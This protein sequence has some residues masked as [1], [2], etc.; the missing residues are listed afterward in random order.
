MSVLGRWW[1]RVGVVD[2]AAA[3]AV[4]AEE[5]GGF[6]A[7]DAT[8]R[9]DA[10][11]GDVGVG[12]GEDGTLLEAHRQRIVALGADDQASDAAPERRAQAHRARLAA[13][14]QLVRGPTGRTERERPD[15]LLREHQ[16]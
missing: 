14:H 4:R 15:A 10:A 1:R 2:E 9:F 11:G 13:G 12:L 6:C 16:R 7:A 8:D 5:A 3:V